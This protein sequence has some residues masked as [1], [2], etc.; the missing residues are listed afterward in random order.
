MKTKSLLAV[1]F[2]GVSFMNANFAIA[3]KPAKIIKDA[4][5]VFEKPKSDSSV[6]SSIPKDVTIQVS[7]NPTNGYYKAR[8]PE[9]KIGWIAESDL[10]TSAPVKTEPG[11]TETVQA[12][13]ISPKSAS[14]FSLLVMGG[15]QVLNNGGFPAEIST[16]NASTGFGGTL[17]LHYKFKDHLILAGKAEYFSSS[18]AQTPSTGVT[19]EFKFST[20]PL[21]AGVIVVPIRKEKYKIGLGLFGGVSLMTSLKI[22][23][24]SGSPED[25]TSARPCGSIN[26][27][28]NY[29]ISSW[30][31]LVG[32]A[33]YRFHSVV[34]PAS[35]KVTAPAFTGNFGGLVLRAGAEFQL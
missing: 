1:L 15:M 5:N 35:T 7:N 17:E 23:K 24:S 11:K 8:T 34:Y 27:Q 3:A 33:G 14:P 20:L 32:D 26:L 16:T 22:N 18:S 31:S 28:G 25:Y 6:I 10:E 30:V 12:K 4:I 29:S 19:Q 2:L 13:E 9:G 21:M